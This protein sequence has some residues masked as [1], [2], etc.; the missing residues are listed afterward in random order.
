VLSLIA[1]VIYLWVRFGD[2]RYGIG[3]II[4]LSHDVFIALG[5][6]VTSAYLANTVIGQKLL[7][8]DF[9]IDLSMI[10]AILTLVGYSVNDTIVVYDRIRENKGKLS[11]LTPAII[12]DSIN[13]TLSRTIL[14]SFTTLLAV[15]IMYIWGGPGFRGFTY[16]VTIGIAVG[17]YSS[18]AIAAPILIL[19][20]QKA[21]ANNA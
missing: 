8:G 11:K 2:L 7:I 9:K 6:I 17:T 18:I 15:L 1:M 4:S 12:N 14:T 13:Q 10:A 16:V 20:K 21:K 3:A 5:L 19:G